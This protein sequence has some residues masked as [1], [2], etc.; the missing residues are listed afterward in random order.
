M[1]EP[2]TNVGA[3]G[4]SWVIPWITRLLD[5]GAALVLFG[6]MAMTFIDVIAREVFNEPLD[7]TTDATLLMLAA[8]VYAVLPVVSRYE[9]HVAVDLLD[10]WVPKWA[11]RPRQFVINVIAAAIFGLMAWQIWIIA[12]EKVQEGEVTQF[13]EWPMAPIFF[14]ISA[15][16]AL[17]AVALLSTGVL[18]LLGRPPR[19]PTGAP[20]SFD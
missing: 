16:S 10:R 3:A 9:Q 15:M 8:T 6:L 2:Q 1:N 19:S 14:F 18:Y 20:P 17:T 13:V 5:W 7:M 4:E 12:T 11:I